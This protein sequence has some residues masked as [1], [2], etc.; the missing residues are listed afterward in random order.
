MSVEVYHLESPQSEG[1]SSRKVMVGLSV[2]RHPGNNPYDLRGICSLV[3]FEFLA[4][5]TKCTTFVHYLNEDMALYLFRSRLKLILRPH[6]SALQPVSRISVPML[7][8]DLL[9]DFEVF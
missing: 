2:C 6:H 7:Y 8:S 1:N 9:L 5:Y 3:L 4:I